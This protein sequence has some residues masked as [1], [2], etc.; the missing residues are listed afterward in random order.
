MAEQEYICRELMEAIAADIS[1]IASN[2]HTEWHVYCPIAVA[3]AV[4]LTDSGRDIAL[5]VL[6]FTLALTIVPLC[7]WVLFPVHNWTRRRWGWYHRRVPEA[8][9]ADAPPVDRAAD[10]AEELAK[11]LPERLDAL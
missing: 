1:I 8:K 3:I 11:T 7:T 2:S 4:F 10:A 5:A 6:R 9:W